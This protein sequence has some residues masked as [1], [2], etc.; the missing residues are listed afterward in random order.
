ML[1]D[2]DEPLVAGGGLDQAIQGSQLLKEGTTL[3]ESAQLK[4]F[5]SSGTM[6]AGPRYPPAH[7]DPLVRTSSRIPDCPYADCAHA[8]SCPSNHPYWILTATTAHH[9]ETC[10]FQIVASG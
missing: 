2:L 3:A 1:V 6:I 9:A 5:R 4:P 8:F 7:A 10:D